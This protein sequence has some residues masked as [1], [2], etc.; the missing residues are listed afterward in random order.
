MAKLYFRYGAMG[1]SKTAN[2]IMVQYNYQERGQAAL[3]L[4]PRLDDRDGARV[5]GSRSGL[6][7]PC[8][9]VEELPEIDV[10]QYDCLIVD[11]AQ[12][13][14]REQVAFLVKIVDEMDIPVICYG[15]RADFQGN[16]FEGSLWLLAWADSIEE[17]KTVCWCGRKATCN[18]RV[19]GGRVT[20]EGAQ[21]M[22]GGSESYVA[23]CRKHWASGEL[24]PREIRRIIN[25]KR[26]FMPLL[27]EAD[28]EPRAIDRYLDKSDLYVL[29]ES[30]HPVSEIALYERADGHIEIK[31]LAT[32]PE[33]RGKG[34]AGE[35]IRHAVR[36]CAPKYRKMYVGTDS[37]MIP[38]YEK[39]GF[40]PD[41]VEPNFFV[42]NYESPIVV[43]GVTLRDMQ[44]LS[45][46]LDGKQGEKT[47]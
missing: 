26:E 18:T 37:S 32:D 1:S 12:F 9:F 33:A 43:D 3:M 31:S 16:L 30:G 29:M 15:L 11:E 40:K 14:N 34:Y 38:Y 39:F 45:M 46:A 23:L 7:A 28:P 6:S 17:L 44:I 27:L 2:A 36:L 5:V 35:L 21:I 4:K 24:A 13:M 8:A 42:D 25:G 19:V 10:R 47:V 20:K 22:L 41:Y